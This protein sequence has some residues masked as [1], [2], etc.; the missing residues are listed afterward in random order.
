[1]FEE[2]T[3]TYKSNI[4]LH[5]WTAIFL[6]AKDRLISHPYH[7]LHLKDD[8][9]TLPVSAIPRGVEIEDTLMLAPLP[10]STCGVGG[11]VASWVLPCPQSM[12]TRGRDGA[13]AKGQPLQMTTYLTS[14][15]HRSQNFTSQMTMGFLNSLMDSQLIS[16]FSPSQLNDPVALLPMEVRDDGI[17]GRKL[18]PINS[19]LSWS[20]PETGGCPSGD[21]DKGLTNPR[22]SLQ[23]RRPNKSSRVDNSHK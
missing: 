5:L 22:F 8:L 3:P 7:N 1:M 18:S 17:I 20:L 14:Q 21:S 2:K 23:P 13:G 6:W 11:E 10:P 9:T 12:P 16:L 4:C 15:A 19:S